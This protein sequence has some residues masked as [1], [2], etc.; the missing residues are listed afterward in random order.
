VLDRAIK[1]GRER[2]APYLGSARFDRTCRNHGSCGWC[3]GNRTIAAQ[4]LEAALRMSR[5]ELLDLALDMADELEA[6]VDDMGNQLRAIH[7]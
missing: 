2:R 4:R 3:H 5:S 7:G 6:I 1:S